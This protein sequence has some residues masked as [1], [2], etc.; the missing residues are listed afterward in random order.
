MKIVDDVYHL[1]L[2]LLICYVSVRVFS[3]W[4]T[5][6]TVIGVGLFS[7]IIFFRRRVKRLITKR[8]KWLVSV[9]PVPSEIDETSQTSQPENKNRYMYKEYILLMIMIF[10][11]RL[12]IVSALTVLGAY[13]LIGVASLNTEVMVAVQAVIQNL[14]DI[15]Y[16]EK[17]I[18]SDLGIIVNSIGLVVGIWKFF[19]DF[20]QIK[21]EDL[22]SDR[23]RELTRR[24]ERREQDI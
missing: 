19:I 4:K 15:T 16:F 2:S 17:E 11:R 22:D 18:F 23:F 8:R 14:P 6:A 10:C 5:I 3:W 1:L 13:L 12:I 24:L 7:F 20:S 21:Q 9:Q